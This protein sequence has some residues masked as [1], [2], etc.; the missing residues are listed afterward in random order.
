MNCTLKR[1]IVLRHNGPLVSYFSTVNMDITGKRIEWST[2]SIFYCF[3]VSNKSNSLLFY[4]LYIC[5]LSSYSPFPFP[6]FTH[7]TVSTFYSNSK[8]RVFLF[9][10]CVCVIGFPEPELIILRL[11]EWETR[12]RTFFVY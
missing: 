7:S 10:Y 4:I 11:S 3:L 6:L 8:T 5:F 1:N 2:V 12:E 9:V